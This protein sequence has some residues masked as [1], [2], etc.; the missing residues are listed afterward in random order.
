MMERKITKALGWFSIGLGAAEV[1]APR[2]LCRALG[3]DEH[4][5]LVRGFGLREIGAGIGLLTMQKPAKGLWARVAGDALDIGALGAAVA[6]SRRRA[7]AIG[8]LASVV[9]ITVLDAVMA[10]RMQHA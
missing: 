3:V 8:A 9:G 7:V 10:R 2:Q 1:L 4:N 5:K 6:K